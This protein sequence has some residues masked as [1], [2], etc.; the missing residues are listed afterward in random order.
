VLYRH[1][2]RNAGGPAFAILGLQF[3][4]LLGGAVF[5]EQI[6][7]LPGMGQLAISS[8]LA[9]DI[10]VVMGLVVWMAVIVV[11]VN[12]LVD[13]AHGALNPKARR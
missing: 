9:S 11:V 8:A 10:P 7:G 6:F 2:L 4:V 3:I 5:V 12:L 13:L 1:V